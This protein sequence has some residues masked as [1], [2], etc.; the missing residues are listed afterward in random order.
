MNK[1]F[2]QIFDLVEEI[3]PSNDLRNLI[4][5]KI[6]RARRRQLL[7]KLI[8]DGVNFCVSTI[9]TTIMTYGV[10]MSLNSMAFKELISL[11]WSDLPVVVTYWQDFAY[12][13]LDAL[14]VGSLFIM[15]IALF[16]AVWSGR[17]FF[18]K[19]GELR[20]IKMF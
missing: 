9:L 11:A 14:P 4:F 3:K 12:A 13:I 10:L 2:I 17:D 16:W 1:E 19:G 5:Q 15:S 20:K 18:V 6:D 7:L 8:F